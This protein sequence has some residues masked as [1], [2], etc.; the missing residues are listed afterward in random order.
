MKKLALALLALL[1]VSGH[2]G[3]KEDG[4]VVTQ[5]CRPLLAAPLSEQG[6][7]TASTSGRGKCENGAVKKGFGGCI[8]PVRPC[9]CR[10]VELEAAAKPAKAARPCCCRP[11]MSAPLLAQ[12]A[13]KTSAPVRG[14]SPSCIRTRC[15][16]CS[17]KKFCTEHPCECK[18]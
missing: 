15:P 13:L 6:A 10:R 9:C 4:G 5:E 1:A 8:D 3:G 7:L 2:G 11:V 14:R 17:D 18:D 12:A 16:D